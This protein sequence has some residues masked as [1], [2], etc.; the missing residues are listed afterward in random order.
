MSNFKGFAE[1]QVP[2]DLVNKLEYDLERVLKSPQD[3]YAAFDF[4]VT[5]E[6]IVDWIHPNDKKARYKIRYNSSLLKITSHIANGVKHFE[7]TAP[8]HQS[9]KTVEKTRYAETGY[10]EE[11]YFEDHLIVHLTEEEKSSFGQRSIKVADLAKQVYDYWS[12]NAP[13]A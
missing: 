4:F 13:Q 12:S 7:A 9:V 6:H 3:Q 2:R 11:G 5:A 10:V 8:H 1:L